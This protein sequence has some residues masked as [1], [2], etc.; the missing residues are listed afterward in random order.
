MEPGR[1]QRLTEPT[2]TL[3]G[4]AGSV[5]AYKAVY[6]AR[7]LGEAGQCVQAILTRSA[8]RFVGP[9]SFSALTGRPAIVDLW[10]GLDHVQLGRDA[11]CMAVAPCTADLLTRLALRRAD[12]PVTATWQSCSAPKLIAP[13]MESNMWHSVR[14]YADELRAQ[15]VVVL[16]PGAGPLASGALGVGRMAEP[17]TILQHLDRLVRPQDFARARVLVT[18]GPTRA[19]LDPIRFLSNASSGKMGFALAK[20]AWAR[21]AAVKVVHGPV[22]I[23]V[24]EGC[25]A[26]PV[27][28]TDEMLQACAAQI[29]W[30]NVLIMAAAP[31]DFVATPAPHKLKKRAGVPDLGLRPAP[32]ILNTLS[33]EHCFSVGF[34]A[35][36]EDLLGG[37]RDKLQ[38]KRLQL[39]V[40]NDA[41]AFT[42]DESAVTLLSPGA[43]PLPLPRAHKDA[44]AHH[45][46]DRVV[47]P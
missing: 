25:E 39:I 13:A 8:C 5:A 19:P 18:A 47:L 17:E 2:L 44:Q 11:A 15:G 4:V 1:R 36:T 3:L 27:A 22:A 30:A 14:G 34:A 46:L 20:A 23:A 33:R 38:R 43:E 6:L 31:C 41:Q 35:E 12:D 45:I 28:T 9:L 42:S 10:S 32:D 21:G 26:I 7:R 40:A 16:D 37:A 24:P 29:P